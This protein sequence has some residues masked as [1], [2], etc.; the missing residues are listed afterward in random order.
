MEGGHTM[1]WF[2]IPLAFLSGVLGRMGGAGKT[3]QW[4]DRFL[5][6]KWRDL[7]CPTILLASAV[8]V[9]G[10]RPEAWLAYSATY[11]L[12]FGALTTYYDKWFGKDCFWFSGLMCGLA[13]TPLIW[14]YPENWYWIVARVG[15]LTIVW[16]L[17]TKLPPKVLC[18]RDDVFADNCR[19]AATL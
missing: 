6:T 13:G 9:W 19:Y 18:W 8:V 16:H 2:I 3:G 11:L 15:V 5:D 14:A 10:W 7:G 1:I 4:Y 12:S 17:L